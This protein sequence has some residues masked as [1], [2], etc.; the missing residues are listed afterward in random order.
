MTIT[1]QTLVSDFATTIP[2][3]VGILQRVGI[4][5]CCGGRKPL[6]VA[7]EEHS[8]S[9]AGLAREIEACAADRQP[10]EHDWTREPL[11]ALADHIVNTYHARLREDLPRLGQMAARVL[12][13]H[14]ARAPRLLGCL[15]AIVRELSADLGEHMKKEE[16]VLFPSIRAMEAG[17]NASAG[18]CRF[19]PPIRVMERDHDHAGE[20]LAELRDITGG[21]VT[22]DWACG[23]F[24]SLYRGLEELEHDMHVHVHLSK[25]T[26]SSRVRCASPRPYARPLC[27]YAVLALLRRSFVWRAAPRR[28]A[29]A[30]RS[31][32]WPQRNQPAP[33]RCS[34]RS[35]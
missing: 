24:R 12:R 25:T 8:L 26:C 2:A 32:S 31:R 27:G 11:H 14:G 20:L 3:S 35:I 7:C 16:L 17:E 21:Y 19:P 5:F 1:E 10:D 4:D 28:S 6:A 15:E 34:A 9:F 29:S 30:R 13:V 22:P 33:V 23:T 18:P